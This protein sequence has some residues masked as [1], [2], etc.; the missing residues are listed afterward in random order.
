MKSSHSRAVV[1][2]TWSRSVGAE[3]V[4]GR[5]KPVLER[6]AIAAPAGERAADQHVDRHAAA[7]GKLDRAEEDRLVGAGRLALDVALAVKRQRE[8]DRRSRGPACDWNGRGRG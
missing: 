3:P 4:E 6:P 2:S 5:A 7:G 1:C 8:L